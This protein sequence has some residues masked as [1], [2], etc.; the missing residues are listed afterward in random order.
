MNEKNYHLERE[1]ESER[2]DKVRILG[3]VTYAGGVINNGSSMEV[4]ETSSNPG[5]FRK[6]PLRANMLE[7]DINSILG[8][9]GVLSVNHLYL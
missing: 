1:G 4:G 5:W 6:I 7:N 9:V 3:T 8:L 2:K